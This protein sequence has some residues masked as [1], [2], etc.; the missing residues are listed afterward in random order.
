MTHAR[1]VTAAQH[2]A[3]TETRHLDAEP[4]AVYGAFA[5]PEV[6][7]RWFKLPGHGAT[8]TLDFRIG[9]GDRARGTFRHLD[10]T[11]E[12][13]EYRSRYLDIVPDR[14]IVQG[15]ESLVDDVLRWTSLVTVEL[16][17]E[18]R[19]TSLTWTEQ[20]AF[21]VPTGDGAADLAHLRG[22]VRLRLNGLPAAIEASA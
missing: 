2:T 11:E 20:A 22:A 13:V 9:G 10:G 14:R 1:A 6:L 19:G 7:R 4:R 5:D 15:Y 8:Y 12:R 18:G 16:T 3:F 21:L 17:P